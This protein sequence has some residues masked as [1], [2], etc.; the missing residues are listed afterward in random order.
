MLG[1]QPVDKERRQYFTLIRTVDAK[2]VTSYFARTSVTTM[3]KWQ[4]DRRQGE[5]QH[6]GEEETEDGEEGLVSVRVTSEITTPWH[7][8][9]R[10][11]NITVQL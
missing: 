1:S 9:P 8:G 2:S 4:P 5:S 10:R 3:S 7:R 11:G 6:Y